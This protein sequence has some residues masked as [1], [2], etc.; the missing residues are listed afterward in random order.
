MSSRRS[1][2]G[3]T[4]TSMVLMRKSRSC[5]KRPETTS[6][7]RSALV[8]DTTRT[9]T[10]RVI[11][12]P[13]RSNSPVSRT[14]SSLGWRLIGTLAISSRK[15]VPPSAISKRPKRS[16]LASVNAPRT[17]PNSSLSKT[18]SE[19]PPA[20]TVIRGLLARAERACSA[21]AT[22]PLP[23]PFSPVTSTLASEGTQRA[24]QLHLRAHDAEQAGIVPGLGDEIAR[25]PAHRLHGQLHA[26]PRRHHHHRQ[27]PV[28]GLQPGQEVEPLLA[29]R[30][31]A[32]VVEVDESDV[33]LALL[34]RRE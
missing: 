22:V 24:A 12:E 9:S 7:R 23:E 25:P 14:R 13:T 1:R 20:L 3:G 8:A 32:R 17:W 6:W 10:R 11:E 16:A 27:R 2:R 33:D 19:S 29:R 28:D 26:R 18:P 5:R 31:V 34:K 4:C 21:S 15:S 30:G